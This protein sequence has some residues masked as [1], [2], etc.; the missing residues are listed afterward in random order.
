M[1]I[2]GN[3][4]NGVI[5]DLGAEA[6]PVRY[7]GQ[8]SIDPDTYQT[9][10]LSN[11]ANEFFI[12]RLNEGFI[13]EKRKRE[14]IE[15]SS[16]AGSFTAHGNIPLLH[17]GNVAGFHPIASAPAMADDETGASFSAITV[18]QSTVDSDLD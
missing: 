18:C 2:H 17:T 7:N 3:R 12:R 14:I 8:L 5:E 1:R 11:E 6:V 4:Y 15:R 16:S 13:D 10:L 9:P